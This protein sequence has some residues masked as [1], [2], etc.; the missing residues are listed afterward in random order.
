MRLVGQ[1]GP[2]SVQIAYKYMTDERWY[3]VRNIC[4]VLAEMKDPDLAGHITPALEHAD[5]R[6][7]QAA[8]KAL[9]SSRTVRAAPVLAASLSKFAPSVVDEALDE[10]M[11]LRHVK[12]VRALE[13]FIGSSGNPAGAR[14]ALQVLAAIDDDDALHA[15]ARLFHREELDS[16]LR[17]AALNALCQHQS[18][19]A[20]ELLQQLAASHGSLADEAR[21]ELRVR[22][23]T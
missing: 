5:A 15:L 19:V 18:P 23:A 2:T 21:A 22:K 9:I 12:T 4:G 11:F 14:K 7:Q 20:V 10:L 16:K 1:L 8:L 17:R 6:V 3:V 13:E